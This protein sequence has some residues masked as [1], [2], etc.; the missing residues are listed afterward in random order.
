MPIQGGGGITKPQKQK[1]TGPKVAGAG[2]R[3]R[4]TAQSTSRPETGVHGTENRGTGK[5]K[6]KPNAGEGVRMRRR[7]AMRRKTDRSKQRTTGC[8]PAEAKTSG[9][10]R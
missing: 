9:D 10:W 6:Q 1:V 4:R 7:A 3:M 8:A 2:R 5:M